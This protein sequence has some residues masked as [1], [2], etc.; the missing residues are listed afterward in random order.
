MEKLLIGSVWSYLNINGI[1]EYN[2]TRMSKDYI[3][4]LRCI[5]ASD[6]L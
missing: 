4:Y 3:Q 5:A 2:Q 6:D 1:T